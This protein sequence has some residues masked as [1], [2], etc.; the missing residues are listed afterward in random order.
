MNRLLLVLLF[1]LC[2]FGQT[3]AVINTGTTANDGTGDS[4]RTF[5]LKSNTNFATLWA[6]VYT[7]GVTKIGTNVVLSGSVVLDGNLTNSFDFDDINQLNLDG[8]NTDIGGVNALFLDGG[9]TT[10]RGVTNLNLITPG[11]TAGTVSNGYVLR[12]SNST[13]GAVEFSNLPGSIIT[14]TATL[15]S[16]AATVT[17]SSITATSRIFLTTQSVS[18]AHGFLHVVSRSNG[19]SFLVNSSNG[20]DNSSF[21]WMIVQP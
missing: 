12:L 17:N 6:S 21:A 10:L 16:G 15:S 3:R 7:N 8:M 20:G 11:V 9:I 5:G 18:G 14:G 19:V 1:P 2:L 4:L 13:E